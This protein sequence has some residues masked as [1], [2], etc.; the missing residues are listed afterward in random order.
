METTAG[1]E[2]FAEGGRGGEPGTRERRGGERRSGGRRAEDQRQ[3]RLELAWATGWA[4][5]GALVVLYLFFVVVGTVDPTKALAA[6]IAVLVLAVAWLAHAWYR[7][8][9]R[10]GYVSRPDREQR[11]F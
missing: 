5:V 4:V 9:V 1:E 11:G 3:A 10:G 8:V 2:G 7:V 6:S